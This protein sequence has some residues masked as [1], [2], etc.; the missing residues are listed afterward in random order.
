VLSTEGKTSQ[1]R[2]WDE[3]I[4]L[5]KEKVPNVDIESGL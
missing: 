5:F 4:A 1:Q 2:I 3:T